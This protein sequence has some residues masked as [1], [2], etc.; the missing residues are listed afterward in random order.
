MI[1]FEKFCRIIKSLD[2][3]M[4]IGIHGIGNGRIDENKNYSLDQIGNKIM[5]EGLELHGWG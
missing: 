3:N 1:D 4:S 5:N 2:D